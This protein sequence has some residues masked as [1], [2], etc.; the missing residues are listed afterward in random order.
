MNFYGER[1]VNEK[2]ALLKNME[3]ET[4]WRPKLASVLVMVIA[5]PVACWSCGKIYETTALGFMN[6]LLWYVMAIVSFVCF[7][8]GAACLLPSRTSWKADAFFLSSDLLACLIWMVSLQIAHKNGNYLL[9]LPA[10]IVT[11]VLLLPM[12]KSFSWV[13]VMRNKKTKEE[14]YK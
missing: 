12:F 5:V 8:S 3:N 14:Q 6:Q 1:S 4:L 10:L 9:C 7:A 13:E 11:F 2:F